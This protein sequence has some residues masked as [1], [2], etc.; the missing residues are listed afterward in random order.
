[1]PK[2]KIKFFGYPNEEVYELEQIKNNLNFDEAVF[3]VEG[4][5]VQ[6]YDKLVQLAAQ[7]EYKDKEFLEIMLIPLFEGG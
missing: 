7:D 5:R 2:L 6:S 4:Q 3:M 1:M